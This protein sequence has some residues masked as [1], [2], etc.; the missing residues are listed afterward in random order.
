M[1]FNKKDTGMPDPVM[2]KNAMGWYDRLLKADARNSASFTIMSRK[3]K[4][5]SDHSLGF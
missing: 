3:K 2:T 1:T 4:E 5:D